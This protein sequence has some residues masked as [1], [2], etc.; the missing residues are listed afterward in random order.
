L[1]QAEDRV[2]RIGQSNSVT[3]QYLVAK[4]TADDYLWP[5]IQKKMSVLKAGGLDQDFLIDSVEGAEQNKNKQRDLT[6]FLSSSSSS[7][8]GSQQSQ[9][10][11]EQTNSAV[12][13]ASVSNDIKELLDID[14]ECFDS[15]DWD[16]IV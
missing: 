1:R 13:K 8:K 12:P 6:S 10:D 5:L 15:C 7:E 9:H 16:E 14:E 3:I 2:H 4:N 11:K